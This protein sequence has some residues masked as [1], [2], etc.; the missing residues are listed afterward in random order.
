M[1]L[2]ASLPCLSPA[3]FLTISYML[4]ALPLAEPKLPLPPA[5]LSTQRHI[6]AHTQATYTVTQT[7]HTRAHMLHTHR[8]PWGT[9]PHKPIQRH[10]RTRSYNFTPMCTHTHT[11]Y[12]HIG[13]HTCSLPL[14]HI[15]TQLFPEPSN[16]SN[17]LFF[18][19]LFSSNKLPS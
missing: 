19:N 7:H 8:H 1:R 2:V 12:T 5:A 3:S 9:H 11:Y 16:S 14:T 17:T 18:L 15:L 6:H 4:T 10:V 13:T